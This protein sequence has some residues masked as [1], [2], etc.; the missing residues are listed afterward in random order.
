MHLC[1][2][3][4][5]YKC[6]CTRILSC[7]YVYIYIPNGFPNWFSTSLVYPDGIPLPHLGSS[8]SSQTLSARDC[9]TI[10]AV[11]SFSQE[12]RRF[13]IHI[14][15]LIGFYAYICSVQ[16]PSIIPLY[17]SVFRNSPVGLLKSPIYWVV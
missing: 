2:Y 16:N 8:K 5:I 9:C 4:H 17:W 14:G 3:I 10:L 6:K 7:V 11:T 15:Y 12:T 1:I 13:M